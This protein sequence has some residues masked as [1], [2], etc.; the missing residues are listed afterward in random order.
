MEA[1]HSRG[2]WHSATAEAAGQQSPST[3]ATCTAPHGL[4]PGLGSHQ[5]PRGD[6]PAPTWLIW[7]SQLTHC[8][9][10]LDLCC[11]CSL[12]LISKRP[13]GRRWIQHGSTACT[14]VDTHV[15]SSTSFSEGV[16]QI[17]PHHRN[18]SQ[19]CI[20]LCHP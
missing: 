10:D 16:P 13:K 12:S 9:A 15:L 3:P 5:A 20:E 6:M 18:S 2:G 17:C 1:T 14:Q 7:G 8:T 4:C 19:K 11:C